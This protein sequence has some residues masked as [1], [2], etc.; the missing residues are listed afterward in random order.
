MASKVSTNS[1]RKSLEEME[2]D[3]SFLER[4]IKTFYQT[5]QQKGDLYGQTMGAFAQ[6]A[7]KELTD[8][9]VIKKMIK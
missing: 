5:E 8:L 9:K 2:R 3:I 1:I 4:E 6:Q 7:R